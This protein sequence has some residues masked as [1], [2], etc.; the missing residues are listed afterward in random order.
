MLSR[1]ALLHLQC[2]P[3]GLRGC[4]GEDGVWSPTL[5][6]LQAVGYAYGFNEGQIRR[7][8]VARINCLNLSCNPWTKEKSSV[9]S[10]QSA[11]SCSS[12]GTVGISSIHQLLALE[13]LKDEINDYAGASSPLIDLSK[14]LHNK[15]GES[16]CHLLQSKLFSFFFFLFLKSKHV[17]IGR[18]EEL[19][20]LFLF[21]SF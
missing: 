8:S 16:I 12:S 17:T 5:S 18:N 21:L 14:W 15:E 20:V 9:R 4:D 7:T 3:L 1:L 13:G 10:V 2:H 6:V 11:H 19:L